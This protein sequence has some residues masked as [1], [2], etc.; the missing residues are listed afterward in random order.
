M[1]IRDP[2][3]S[4]TVTNGKF[5]PD[6]A[7]LFKGDFANFEGMRVEVTIK[8]SKRKDEFNRYY[9]VAIVKTF[10]DFFNQEK[11][12]SRVVKSDFVHEIL[13]AKFLGF[14][15]QTIPGG[16]VLNMRT[17]SRTLTQSEFYDYTKYCKQWGEEFFGL[18]FPELPKKN[19]SKTSD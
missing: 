16:E 10:T 14:T 8:E 17:P 18:T 1:I 7:E 2:S 5:I 3:H 4:G 9:W 6:N 15:Q 13:A 19:E 12:F 11:S